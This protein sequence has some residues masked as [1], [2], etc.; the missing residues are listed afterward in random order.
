MF[1]WFLLAT[2]KYYVE[3]DL[4]ESLPDKL[5]LLLLWPLKFWKAHPELLMLV[6]NC[7]FGMAAMPFLFN[8]L[9]QFI[10]PRNNLVSTLKLAKVHF[11]YGSCPIPYFNYLAFVFNLSSTIKKLKLNYWMQPSFQCQSINITI[12]YTDVYERKT[13]ASWSTDITRI[14]RVLIYNITIT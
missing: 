1:L 12:V 13:H 6:M 9:N 5:M 4:Q 11:Y 8:G 10:L 2:C 14:I 3:L 7:T